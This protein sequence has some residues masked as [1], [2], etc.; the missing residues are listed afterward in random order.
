MVSKKKGTDSDHKIHLNITKELGRIQLWIQ[1]VFKVTK[2]VYQSIRWYNDFVLYISLNV[3]G[4]NPNVNITRLSVCF[5]T[6]IF[7]VK[8]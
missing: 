1:P 8:N 2:M 7:P 6:K 4:T 3:T 5:K